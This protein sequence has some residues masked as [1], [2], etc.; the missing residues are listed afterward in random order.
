M[1][2]N[3][4]LTKK[5][6]LNYQYYMIKLVAHLNIISPLTNFEKAIMTIHQETKISLMDIGEK[7]QNWLIN[8]TEPDTSEFPRVM[9]RNVINH[10]N[11]KEFEEAMNIVAESMIILDIKNP[12]KEER[13]KTLKNIIIVWMNNFPIMEKCICD[14]CFNNMM[15]KF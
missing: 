12:T 4:F 14:K 10:T 2:H 9:W 8:K 1:L 6:A 5:Q 15:N 3:N 7:I 11:T 13:L